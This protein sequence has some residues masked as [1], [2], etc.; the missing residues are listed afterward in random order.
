MAKD[1]DDYIE[2]RTETI[3]ALKR[4]TKDRN[5]FFKLLR[6][7]SDDT[8][9]SGV[10]GRVNDMERMVLETTRLLAETAKNQKADRRARW[11][12]I[13][14][15]AISVCATVVGAIVLSRMGVQ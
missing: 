13:V 5:T 12:M 7:S 3:A 1:N 10:I 14:G 9:D 4:L 11:A 2:F 6:G 8:H 15:A